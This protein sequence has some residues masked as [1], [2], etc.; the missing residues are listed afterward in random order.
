METSPLNY[1]KPSH[2]RVEIGSLFLFVTEGLLVLIILAL[3]ISLVRSY[4]TMDFLEHCSDG[5][6]SQL[7]SFESG[8]V[9]F[10][11]EGR[12]SMSANYHCNYE[13]WKADSTGWENIVGLSRNRWMPF[14]LGSWTTS[15]GEHWTVFVMPHWVLIL[16]CGLPALYFLKRHQQDK[17]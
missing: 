10:L 12:S 14:R 7:V 16:I 2:P 13:S 4:Y 1:E 8:G 5:R 6:N 9:Y 3:V 15:D 11:L 17:A